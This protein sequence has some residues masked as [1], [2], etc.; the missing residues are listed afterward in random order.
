MKFVYLIKIEGRDLYKI[1]FCKDP[2]KRIKQLQTGCPYNLELIYTYQSPH[3]TKLEKVLHTNFQFKKETD[4]NELK[5]EWFNLDW[6]DEN[7][8]EEECK[9]IE[10]N[11]NVINNQ[12]TINLN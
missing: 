8:F 10:K 7:N 1:G 12:S 9:K 4:N 11:I 2:Q 3:A 5:G 6:E